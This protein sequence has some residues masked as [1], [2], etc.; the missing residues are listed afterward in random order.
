MTCQ[1]VLAF[2]KKLRVSS[3][4]DSKMRP[5][6][7]TESSAKLEVDLHE[8]K[9]EQDMRKPYFSKSNEAVVRHIAR[10]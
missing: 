10:N 8:N 6:Q 5:T 9:S 3:S 2:L 4:L 7:S 1:T